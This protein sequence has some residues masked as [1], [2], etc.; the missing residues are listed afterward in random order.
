MAWAEFADAQATESAGAA[1]ASG[2]FLD[3]RRIDIIR[4]QPRKQGWE[5]WRH[6]PA[7]E[8]RLQRCAARSFAV[9]GV[10]PDFLLQVLREDARRPPPGLP[11]VAVEASSPPT[12]SVSAVTHLAI[13]GE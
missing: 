7:P 5:Y 3:G 12:Q 6:R 4:Q 13:G 8:W 1:A 11:A 10:L 9:T 2:V